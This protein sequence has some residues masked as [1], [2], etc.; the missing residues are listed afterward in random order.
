MRDFFV[1][2]ERDRGA[3]HAQLAREWEGRLVQLVVDIDR[4]LT[5]EQR[6]KLVGRFES[7][8]RIAACSRGRAGPRA[9]R[10]RRSGGRA[11]GGSG[12]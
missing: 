2:W 12:H 11:R 3:E 8:P 1:D 9:R 7:S 10:A 5:P 4:T 6:A